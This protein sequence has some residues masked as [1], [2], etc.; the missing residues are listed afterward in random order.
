MVFLCHSWVTVHSIHPPQTSKKNNFWTM[1][2]LIIIIWRAWLYF[3]CEG[4][5]LKQ[6]TILWISSGADF[7]NFI[8]TK[9][10]RR[11]LVW[12]LKRFFS[13]SMQAAMA[14][15]YRRPMLKGLNRISAWGPMIIAL[16]HYTYFDHASFIHWFSKRVN[17]L[18]PDFRLCPGIQRLTTPWHETD[19]MVL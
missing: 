8:I 6:M 17:S 11:G 3:P 15:M 10:N 9:W 13:W 12:A 1:A 18:Y 4:S 14:I 5:A 7:F 19:Y 16:I 2:Y